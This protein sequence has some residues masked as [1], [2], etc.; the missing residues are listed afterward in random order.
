MVQVALP[1]TTNIGM[2][3]SSGAAAAEEEELVFFGVRLD[4]RTVL[5]LSAISF[6]LFVIAEVI[7]AFAA[8][9]LSLLG[10][11]GA[12]S[13]DVNAYLSNLYAEHKKKKHGSRL[14]KKT[15][16][17]LEIFIPLFS[18]A[19]LLAVTIYVLTEAAKILT[20]SNPSD[21]VAI[22][23]LFGFSSANAVVDIFC[24]LLFYFRGS[25][26]FF[27]SHDHEHKPIP[28]SLTADRKAKS[29][30]NYSVDIELQ[31]NH[32][33]HS[34]AHDHDL[35]K[36]LSAEQ[37]PAVIDNVSTSS[38]DVRVRNKNTNMMSALTHVSGDTL[39]TMAV[40][41]AAMIALTT[42]IPSETCDAYAAIVVSATIL[43]IIVPLCS[44]IVKSLLK[45]SREPENSQDLSLL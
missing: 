1:G 41:A 31:H 9:S 22:G 42:N 20:K 36:E 30:T 5:W 11:A 6:G 35:H 25:E 33:H 3:S 45:I 37:T 44:E 34:H 7:A 38:I 26:G 19:L 10:D 27:H 17:I 4:N 39:R 15:R 21:S 28:P 40:F 32:N 29:N 16:I 13:V 12:M 24:V 18:V 43:C 23:V 8:N 2:E 14:K